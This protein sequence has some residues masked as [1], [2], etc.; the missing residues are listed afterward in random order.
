MRSLLLALL[1]AVPA[2]SVR[3]AETKSAEPAPANKAG[4]IPGPVIILKLDDV[5]V[6]SDSAALS[7]AW[8]RVV[9]YLEKKKIK[10]S[11][12]IIC[13]S[14]EH[15]NPA[16]LKW[17]KDVQARGMIEFW[18]HGYDHGV[19]T[20]DD[21]KMYNEFNHRT[22][23]EQKE[24]FEKSQKLAKEKLGFA[25]PVFGPPGG[26]YT[27][28]QD[29]NTAKAMTDVP[30]LKVWLYPTPIDESGKK[31]NEQGKVLVLDRVW[32]VG[33][34]SKV[35]QPDLKKLTDGYAKWAGKRAYFVLQGHAA[36]WDKAKWEEFVKIVEFLESKRCVFM[37]PSEYAASLS[38]K[39]E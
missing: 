2:L 28:S 23:E 34:E 27:A 8:L 5:N 13:N 18:C 14:L 6:K 29:A 39:K 9:D 12:G 15:H 16:Y 36:Q 37:T 26:V 4:E 32:E 21:G 24:R 11:L 1:I 20:D 7:G 25:L 33:L 38:K 19:H 31:L 3:A 35:G 17:I 22:Y 10:G 30:E